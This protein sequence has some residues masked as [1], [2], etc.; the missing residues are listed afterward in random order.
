MMQAGETVLLIGRGISGTADLFRQ[1]NASV[2]L[3][4]FAVVD[5]A[6]LALVSPQTIAFPLMGSDCDAAQVLVRLHGLRFGGQAIIFA[7]RLP[8][9][10][11]VLRELRPLAPGLAELSLMELPLA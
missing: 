6:F 5:A 3:G 2:V 7:P 1:Q 8:D 11:M 4:S 10:E 9:G